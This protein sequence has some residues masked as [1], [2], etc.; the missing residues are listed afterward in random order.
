MECGLTIILSHDT[1]SI[2][3]LGL[4][5]KEFPAHLLEQFP[6]LVKVSSKLTHILDFPP[7]NFWVVKLL[8][9]N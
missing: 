4:E 2:I 3:L 8:G 1:S 9:H 7:E 5:S 6:M